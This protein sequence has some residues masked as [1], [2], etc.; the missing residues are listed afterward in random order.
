M[1]NQ[2]LIR[3]LLKD[4]FYKAIALFDDIDWAVMVQEHKMPSYICNQINLEV[5]Q[6]KSKTPS[7]VEIPQEEN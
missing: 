4:R 7:Q 6:L 5:C 2:E 1:L 3:C